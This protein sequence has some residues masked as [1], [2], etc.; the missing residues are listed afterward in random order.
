MMP[1]GCKSYIHCHRFL[2]PQ[3]TKHL[4]NP[5]LNICD[6]NEQEYVL[7]KR[8]RPQEHISHICKKSFLLSAREE[9]ALS[10]VKDEQLAAAMKDFLIRCYCEREIYKEPQDNKTNKR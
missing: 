8:A 1:V 10:F 6:S 5:M 3:L 7:K 4:I 9:Q 2:S